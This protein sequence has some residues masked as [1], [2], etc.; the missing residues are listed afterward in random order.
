MSHTLAM[1]DP[2]PA[3]A[4]SY[5]RF[6]TPE[7]QR[8]DSFRRQK[9]L[10]ER[11]AARHSLQLDGRSFQDLGVSAFRGANA[12][13][14]MLGE[15]LLAVRCGLIPRGSILLVESL[16]RLSRMKPRK[17]L[18]LLEEI[19]ELGIAVVT[20]ADERTYTLETLDE[21]PMGL[22]YALMVAVRANEESETKSR[23]G[24][25]AW[26]AKRAMAERQPLTAVAPAWLRLREDRG[27]FEV[28]EER[29][30]VV[31]RVFRDYLAG[32]G[33]HAIA[34]R[35]NRE[36]VAPFGRAKFWHR[37][38]ILKMLE[39][40]SAVGTFVPHVIDHLSGRKRRVPQ[41]PVPNYFPAIVSVED[42]G[43]VQAMR[44]ERRTPHGRV[45]RPISHLLA[46][47]GRCPGCGSAVVRVNKGS[48][49]KGGRPYLV[50]S[51]AKAGA[52]CT[53]RAV[54]VADAEASIVTGLPTLVTEMPKGSPTLVDV[55]RRLEGERDALEAEM[56]RWLDELAAGG[57][58]RSVSA[59]LRRA[60]EKHERAMAELGKVRSALATYNASARPGRLRELC[61]L[62]AAGAERVAE[63][64]AK[65][66]VLFSGVEV[67]PTARQLVFHWQQGGRTRV[68]LSREG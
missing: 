36:G 11:Y 55:E 15:F 27:G 14:G 51:R 19:C 35:L 68:P 67:D 28:V 64:N 65:L 9:D 12:E 57:P 5:L 16:D 61:D 43:A 17:A 32:V 49:A 2:A 66:R 24:R 45:G 3:L 29:A 18:R 54:H 47:L 21:E 25:A 37:S 40:P 20:L 48:G 10:A 42:F 52:G 23:R 8:G 26:E 30:A 62:L 60:E 7:Q 31:R 59:M 22:M 56:V 58:S 44:A 50:C 46:G 53:Y 1:D 33:P 6:S 63:A 34:E 13:A 38:Y 39:S 4:F 41:D